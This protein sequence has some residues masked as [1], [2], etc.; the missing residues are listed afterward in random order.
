MTMIPIATT[1]EQSER[2]LKCGIDPK[3]ADMVWTRWDNDGERT[4]KLDVMDIHAFEMRCLRPIPAWSLSTL[5]DMLPSNI[6]KRL[7]RCYYLSVG[8][9][10]YDGK[11]SWTIGYYNQWSCNGTLYGYRNSSPIEACVKTIEW[12]AEKG[13]DLNPKYRVND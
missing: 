4:D 11:T 9:S 5:L 13:Y 10:R 6:Q 3:T 2:L 7:P 1:I 8:H 12:I